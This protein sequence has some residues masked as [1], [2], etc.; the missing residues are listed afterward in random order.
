MTIL[1]AATEPQSFD[2][3]GSVNSISTAPQIDT[4]YSRIGCQLASANA[5]YLATLGT[6]Q[7]ITALGGE[8]LWLHGRIWISGN[9]GAATAPFFYL[10]DTT[11][12]ATGLSNTTPGIRP[13]VQ[14]AAVGSGIV[15][16]ATAFGIFDIRIHAG[17]IDYYLD[18]LLQEA[19][20]SNLDG[21]TFTSIEIERG[22]SQVV[23]SEIVLA[24]TNTIGLRVGT[25]VVSAQ[26]SDDAMAGDFTSVDE[27]NTDDSDFV[28]SLNVGEQESFATT[29]LSPTGTQLTPI[30]VAASARGRQGTLSGG[31]TDFDIF[32]TI[33]A[34]RFVI[35]GADMPTVFGAGS[36]VVA[37]QNPAT[38]A[39]WG[40][41]ANDI[42]FG[43]VSKA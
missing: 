7:T 18:G 6:S 21:V 23:A 9:G 35:G 4:D 40:A 17:G 3:I 19:I 22:A 34:N 1:F 29:T 39:A 2:S 28:S 38:A 24:T 12:A 10:R 11:G 27:L 15:R 41:E 37:N 31:P 26:G 16:P 5:R 25:S 20:T 33:G 36:V 43:L 14:G 13:M 42:E 30:A 32:V 8:E